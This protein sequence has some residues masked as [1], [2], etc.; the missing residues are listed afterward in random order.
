MRQDIENE[1][2]TLLKYTVMDN[3]RFTSNERKRA[4]GVLVLRTRVNVLQVCFVALSLLFIT[5]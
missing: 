5:A 3:A 4:F 2:I 1:L